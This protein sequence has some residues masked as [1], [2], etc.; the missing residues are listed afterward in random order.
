MRQIIKQSQG[1]RNYVAKN[2]HK[3]NKAVVYRDRTKYCR[4]DKHKNN[5]W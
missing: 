3:A 4:K 5:L 2:A 1:S